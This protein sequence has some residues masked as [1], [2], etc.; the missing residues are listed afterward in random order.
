MPDHSWHIRVKTT[1]P[2]SPVLTGLIT[3]TSKQPYDSKD[4]S[5]KAEIWGINESIPKK[6]G[7]FLK[8]YIYCSPDQWKQR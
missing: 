3:W 6:S 2:N 8:N 7:L 4:I 5:Y 1:E